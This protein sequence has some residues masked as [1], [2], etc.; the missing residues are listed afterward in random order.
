MKSDKREKVYILGHKNPDSDSVCSAIAY[1]ELKNSLGTGTVYAAGRCGEINSETRFI[2]NYFGVPEPEYVENVRTQIEDIEIGRSEGVNSLIS[3]KTA[4]EIMKEKNIVTLPVVREDNT[5]EGLI[6]TSDIAKSYMDVYDSRIISEAKTPYRNLVEILKGTM[7]VGDIDGVITKGKF[8][9]AAANPELMEDYISEG[10]TVICGNRFEAQLCAVKMKAGC[11]IVC[12]E[13]SRISK[14]IQQTA[15]EKGCCVIKTDFDTFT[16][17]RLVNQSIPIG[18]FMKT[19]DIV[20]FSPCDYLDEIRSVMVKKRYRNF[21]VVLR[22]GELAGMI[23]RRNLIGGRCKKVIL[24]DHNEKL[25]AVDGLEQAE[26]LEVIDHHRIADVETVHPVHFRNQ[27]FG[28]SATIIA[29]IYKENGIK[30]PLKTAGILCS[31]ILSDT[32]VFSSPT[33]TYTDILTARELAET[34]GIDIKEY[35]K[36]MFSAGTSLENKTAEQIFYQ[37]FKMF[38]AGNISFGVGQFNIMGT[39]AL[40]SLSVKIYEHMKKELVFRR[41]DMMFFM[42]TN[43]EDKSSYVIFCGKNAYSYLNNIFNKPE[44][45]FMIHIPKLVS[46]KKQFIPAMITAL[47]TEASI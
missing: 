31:A 33:C 32:L 19:T 28:A 27:P 43:I 44:T 46:R 7:L 6:T 24:V 36:K 47:H 9:I 5:L 35:S 17:A 22:S 40:E 38:N 45:D 39:E 2:L 21:P 29:Q 26:I 18:F 25:Q 3:L 20:T 1:A 13:K 8:I 14:T 10:D 42:L 30:I 34:A 41:A 15:A 37:D 12:C 16:A 23:S 11:I 4:W